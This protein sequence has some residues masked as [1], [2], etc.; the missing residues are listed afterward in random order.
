MALAHASSCLR[1]IASGGRLGEARDWIRRLPAA[2]M[3]RDVGLQLTAAWICSLGDEPASVPHLVEQIRR[4]PQFDA[5]CMLEAALI[6]AAAADFCDQPGRIEEA[7]RDLRQ[8]PADATPL[9]VVS[10]AN[11]RAILALHQGNP[12]GARRILDETI[13][14]VPREPLMRMALGFTDVICGIA[15]LWEGDPEKAAAVLRPRLA[16]AEHE[17][18]RRSVV[19]AMLAGAYAAALYLLDDLD[20]ALAVLADRLDVIER[21]GMPDPIILAYRVLAEAAVRRGDERRA[22][23]T[24]QSLQDVGAARRM[25][26]LVASSL[27]DQVRIHLAAS[28]VE[29]AS[30]LLQTM[31]ALRAA[32]ELPESRPLLRL[33]DRRLAMLTAS[34]S[35]SRFDPGGAETA[36]AAIG[37]VPA[38]LRFNPDVLNSRALKALAAHERGQAGARE[39]LIEVMSLAEL[40]GMRRLIETWHPAFAA[41]LGTSVPRKSTQERQTGVERR[42]AAARTG[43]GEA[44]VAS[45]LLTPKEA[46]ILS[47]LASG[48]ANKE[49]ARAMDIGEQTVKW[50]LKNVFFKLNAAS[51]RHAVDRARVLGLLSA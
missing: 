28:R 37:D 39:Q 47:L 17:L 20:Q 4:H 44:P 46:Q 3:S 25:P 15:H 43:V 7:L 49:I 30:E 12:E 40:R 34:V 32:F 29:T 35:L 24:L 16:V 31:A 41:V 36:L 8:L 48:M 5:M 27:M 13:D 11:T 50:H 14:S 19:A 51:R 22:L 21:A 10:F 33:F 9:H 42:T 26:R 45:G 1:D 38:S 18:G 23:D 6:S 2:A